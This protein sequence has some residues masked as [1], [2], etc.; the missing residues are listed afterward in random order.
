MRSV[1]A[2]PSRG[3]K[4]RGNQLALAVAKRRIQR[5]IRL[6]VAKKF[7]TPAGRS[8]FKQAPRSLPE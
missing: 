4:V 5:K 8:L 1:L 2:E 7:A 6:V 3:N